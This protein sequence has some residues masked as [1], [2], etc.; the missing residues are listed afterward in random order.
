MR[1]DPVEGPQFPA[2]RST[3]VLPGRKDLL[4]GDLIFWRAVDCRTFCRGWLTLPWWNC[5]PHGGERG[6]EKTRHGSNKSNT[7]AGRNLVG[8]ALRGVPLG[9]ERH[10]PQAGAPRSLQRYP[11]GRQIEPCRKFGRKKQC[12]RNH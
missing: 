7:S 9:P 1:D 2:A 10:D 8:N 11:G 12:C 4:A 3:I 5:K 6:S